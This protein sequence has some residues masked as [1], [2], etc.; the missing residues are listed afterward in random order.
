MIDGIKI[1]LN[2]YNFDFIKFKNKKKRYKYTHIA[3]N[4]AEICQKY[5]FFTKEILSEHFCK[6]LQNIS[7]QH[8]NYNF[9]KY[10]WNEINIY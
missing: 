1:G 6:I 8:Y 9:L 5:F 4:I 7:S 10:F 3:Q 2:W